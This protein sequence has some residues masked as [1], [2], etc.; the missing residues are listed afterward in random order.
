MFPNKNSAHKGLRLNQ[1]LAGH[2]G[3]DINR[4]LLQWEIN[5]QKKKKNNIQS[6]DKH[7]CRQVYNI[8]RTLVGS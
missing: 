6:L 4:I 5:I 7:I 1:K 8:S 3:W 2:M